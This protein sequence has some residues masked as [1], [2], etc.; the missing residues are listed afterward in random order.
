[1]SI[2]DAH[3]HIGHYSEG[4][5]FDPVTVASELLSLGISQWAVSSTTICEGTDRFSETLAELDA[6]EAAAPGR[7]VPVLW[8]TPEMLPFKDRFLLPQFRA[9]KIHERAHTWTDTEL[10]AA[11]SLA[12]ESVLPLVVHT[13]G[14]ARCDA[15]AYLDLCRLHCKVSVVLAHG[16]PVEQALEILSE[17][18]NTFADTAFMPA[19]DIMTLIDDGFS[20]RVLWGSDYPL[21]IIFF[22]EEA[23]V[24][25]L[26][27]RISEFK[28][29]V[30][31]QISSQICEQNF[32]HLFGE[33]KQ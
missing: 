32:L 14:S 2:C 29:S 24:K 22:P 20:S 7:V 1:M 8:L 27:I 26:D 11:F 30:P 10:D 15:G 6:M 9:L 21:D 23:P 4:R 17:C 13:G 31:R 12:E 28:K 5:F 25:R 33:P 3:V 16:R 19:K 18:P